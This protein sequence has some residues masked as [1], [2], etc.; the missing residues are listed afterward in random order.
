[1]KAGFD[2]NQERDSFGRFGSGEGVTKLEGC[3]KK[4]E[5]IK[6]SE[7][8]NQKQQ[9]SKI[10]EY[11]HYSG[12]FL[13]TIWADWFLGESRENKNRI[14]YDIHNDK[15]LQA[16]MK[17]GLYDLWKDFGTD[18]ENISFDDFLNSKITVYRGVTDRNKETG[19]INENGFTSYAL[20]KEVARKFSPNVETY[21]KNVSDLFGAVN[22][23]GGEVEILEPQPYSNDFAIRLSSENSDIYRKKLTDEQL[24]KYF[25][26]DKAK[27]RNCANIFADNIINKENKS[28]ADIIFEKAGFKPE[29]IHKT[30]V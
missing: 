8:M 9:T 1:M 27:G 29:Q 18:V 23:V 28:I 3:Y 15:G 17:S 14:A 16:A 21:K 13:N 19:S 30:R 26:I 2:P 12:D 25:E 20:T 4:P 11:T 7:Y 24:N 22:I 5:K 10:R 6:G